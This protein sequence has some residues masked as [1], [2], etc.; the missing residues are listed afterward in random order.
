MLVYL[1]MYIYY[2][3][4]SS[5]RVSLNSL[6]SDPPSIPTGHHSSGRQPVSSR[7]WSRKVRMGQPTEV[8]PCLGCHRRRSLDSFSLLQWLANCN[9]LSQMVTDNGGILPLSS[10]FVRR[11]LQVTL[12]AACSM[13]VKVPSREDCSFAVKVQVVD[14]QTR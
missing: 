13:R 4:S 12:R 3:F 14:P 1:F 7:S 9:L 8:E 2:L 10:L 6:D 11:S 5:G